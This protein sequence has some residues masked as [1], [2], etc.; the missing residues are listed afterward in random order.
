MRAQKRPWLTVELLES[1]NLLDATSTVTNLY[2]GILQRGPEQAGLAFWSGLLNSGV[3]VSVVASA[4]A[5]S[6]EATTIEVTNLYENVLV[7]APDPAGQAFWVNAIQS[8]SNFSQAE[9]GFLGSAEF[10]AKA[11][12]TNAGFIAALYQAALG[13]E[14]D[15]SGSA[16]WGTDLA[17]GASRNSVAKAVVNSPE[18]IKNLVTGIYKSVLNRPPDAAGLSKWTALLQSQGDDDDAVTYGA[19]W[20]SSEAQTITRN[21]NFPTQPGIYLLAHVVLVPYLGLSTGKYHL[22]FAVVPPDGSPAFTIGAGPDFFGHLVQGIDRN[23]DVNQPAD[24]LASLT[25]NQSTDQI[26][27]EIQSLETLTAHSPSAGGMPT[28]DTGQSYN[29]FPGSLGIGGYNSNSDIAGL[30]PLAGLQLPPTLNSQSGTGQPI[31]LKGNEKDFPGITSPLPPGTFPIPAA[32]AR[33][34]AT[35][36]PVG[37]TFSGTFGGKVSESGDDGDGAFTATLQGPAS[38]KVAASTSGGFDYS[39]TVTLQQSTGVDIEDYTVQNG[40]FSGHVARLNSAATTFMVTL[41]EG[42]LNCNGTFSG[43][44]FAGTCTFSNPGDP[45]DSGS[46]FTFQLTKH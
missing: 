29:P 8:G 33:P 12:G 28:A 10:F 6:P 5:T 32:A 3:P 21:P 40:T 23:S 41:N 20:G 31:Q 42:A 24:F 16:F 14:I 7:R 17:N 43:N 34:V 39:G 26:N 44:M 30:A 13:R 9:V 1:R 46:G 2:Q 45:S 27:Q 37:V 38:V 36:P 19:F 18:A 22:L 4:I 25:Q 11:G 15:A 35:T